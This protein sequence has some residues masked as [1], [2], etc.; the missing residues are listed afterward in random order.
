MRCGTGR[1]A[2][3]C[4]WR[5]RR[6]RERWR[7]GE[8]GA[9]VFDAAG[10]GW[11]LKLP[12]VRGTPR[13]LRKGVRNVQDQTAVS[14]GVSRADDRAGAL[15][16]GCKTPAKLSREFE[17]SAQTLIDWVAQ[18]AHD[19]GKPLPDNEGPSSAERE[20]HSVQEIVPE[21]QCN[22]ADQQPHQSTGSLTPALPVAWR[23]ETEWPM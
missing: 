12:R 19:G 9:V 16:A 18:A 23:F 5:R 14:G 15:R 4:G 1:S 7:A 20:E 10:L 2:G 8:G 3:M 11:A 21:P 6:L 22:R 13:L 17:C